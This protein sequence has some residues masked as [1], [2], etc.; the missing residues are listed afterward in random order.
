MSFAALRAARRRTAGAVC[1]VALAASVLVGCGS[2]SSSSSTQSASNAAATGS[3][4]SPAGS[5]G[6]SKAPIK[7]GYAVSLTGANNAFDGPILNGA[8]LAVANYNKAGGVDGHPLQII[9][10]DAA[11]S[12][13]QGATAALQV[14]NDGA[15]IVVPSCD[16]NYGSPGARVAIAHGDLAVGCAGDD[17]Y[18]YQGVGP[19][20]FNVDY[21][22]TQIEGATMAN[23]AKRLGKHSAFL[24][25]DVSID[26][27]KQVCQYFGQVFK[28]LGGT[29]SGEV[30]FENSDPSIASQV[31]KL[32][33]SHNTDVIAMCSYL[34]GLGPAVKQIRAAGIN[35]PIVSDGGADANGWLS[36]VPKLSNFYNNSSGSLSGDDSYANL[37]ALGQQYRATYHS[38]PPTDYGVIFGYS[39]IQLIAHAI[40]AA[41]GSTDGKTLATTIEGFRNI[42][43]DIGPASFGPKC[44]IAKVSSHSISEV[45]NGVRH[46]QGTIPVTDIPA[47]LC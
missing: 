19:L 43:L 45:Q 28:E 1:A 21:L 8:R 18:G 5:S 11:S 29:I 41:N 20:L 12:L 31:S 6:G 13:T 16:Y 26:Y 17:L 36:L 38:A 34:P 35:T 30:T 2:S 27:S 32:A 9:T 47:A 24:F 4:S 39:E 22:T 42:P 44:N 46:F 23:E 37:T 7:I 40:Q 15:K 10:S 14:I 25:Q 33:A 3:T